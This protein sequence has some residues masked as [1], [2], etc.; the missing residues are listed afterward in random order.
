M[1]VQVRK[2]D[3]MYGANC[4]DDEE[5]SMS[6][7]TGRPEDHWRLTWN[8]KPSLQNMDGDNLEK[9]YMSVWHTE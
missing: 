9:G 8:A 2:M 7:I 1:D 3:E 5:R 4:T 6:V